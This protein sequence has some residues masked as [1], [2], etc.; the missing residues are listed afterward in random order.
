[1]AKL[2]KLE[3]LELG[4]CRVIGKAI[5]TAGLREAVNPIPA[6]WARCYADGSLDRLFGMQAYLT[7]PRCPIGYMDDPQEQDFRYLVG[8]YMQP[9][10]PAPEGYDFVDIPA[11]RIARATLC[12]R[13]HEVYAE[14]HDKTI[15]A[16]EQ[17]GG[18]IRYPDH[19]FSA[20]VY[21]SEPSDP[22]HFVLQY[23]M[24]VE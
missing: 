17:N 1:M 7:D 10:T 8:L 14:A 13:E 3:F 23:D 21:V 6:L 19:Y 18:T 2:E 5:R 22:E 15:Q 11:L 16:I 4:P 9:D 24:T 20:E 12:G